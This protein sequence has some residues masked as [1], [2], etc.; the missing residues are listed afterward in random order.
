MASSKLQREN[1]LKSVRRAYGREFIEAIVAAAVVALI[2]RIFVV[3]V[4]RVPT[5]SMM[6]TLIPGDIIVAWKATYGVSIPFTDIKI[7]ERSPARGDVVVFEAPNDTLY[8]KRVV[9]VPGD[10]IEIRAG[11]LSVNDVATAIPKS[12]ADDW[13]IFEETSG[14][15]THRVMRRVTDLEADFLAPQIVP[16]GHIFL[17]GDLRSD[18]FDSRQWGPISTSSLIGR[19]AFIGISVRIEGAREI[20]QVV[21]DE[22]EN[23]WGRTF[24]IIE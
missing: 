9:G 19:A 22:N 24:Q 10:R 11:R 23:R 1:L 21:G 6:P 2:L 5:A 17:L 14:E 20:P 18:S 15:S 8:I 7:G 12:A 16:P 3:S 4:Y 13:E